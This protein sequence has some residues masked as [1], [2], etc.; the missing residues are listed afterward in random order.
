MPEQTLLYRVLLS[1]L[2]TFLDR[3]RTEASELPK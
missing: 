3:T 1:H 2:E